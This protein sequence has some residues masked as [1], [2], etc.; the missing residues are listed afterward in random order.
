M[1][2][3]SARIASLIL[4]AAEARGVAP[5]ELA[6]RAG[7][8]LALL[9]D[10]DATMSIDVEDALW[11][12]AAELTGDDLFGLHS[13]ALLRPGMLDVLDYVVRTAPTIRESMDRLARYNRLMHSD[14]VFTVSDQGDRVRIEHAFASPGRRPSLHASD[15]TIASLI[16]VAR[17]LSG[18]PLAALSVELPHEKR[19]VDAYAE[20][21]GVAPHFD[22]PIGAIELARDDVDRPCPTADAALGQVMLRHAELLLAALPAPAA[23]FAS[24][25]K[26]LL[27]TKIDGGMLSLAAAARELRMSERSLQRKLADE[28]L[29]FEDLVDELRQDLARRYLA[30]PK[31]AIGE[32]AYL[33]GY[34]EPSAFHRAFKRWTGVTPTEARRRA[35]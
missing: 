4:G 33:L 6:R 1:I 32:V 7:F 34:S 17:Q 13:T 25:V 22:R 3:V 12:G 28:N 21:F 5:T 31:I 14:A 29:T 9:Q 35:A 24:R 30:D 23:T 26:Q 27:A 18:G 15:M 10:A 16:V 2:E 8:D 20:V 19:H 11:N